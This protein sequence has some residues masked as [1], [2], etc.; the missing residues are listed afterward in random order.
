MEQRVV[1]LLP[2]SCFFGPLF[3]NGGFII[4]FARLVNKKNIIKLR[5]EPGQ[6]GSPFMN[7]PGDLLIL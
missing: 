2:D 4:S 6:S 7:V 3:L 5:K 1:F